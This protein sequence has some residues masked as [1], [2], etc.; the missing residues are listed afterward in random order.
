MDGMSRYGRKAC[1]DAV[2]LTGHRR[3]RQAPRMRLFPAL[4]LLTGCLGPAGEALAQARPHPA[5]AAP[6][7]GPKFGATTGLGAGLPSTKP[8]PLPP[9][10]DP[11]AGGG[12]PARRAVSS[13]TGFVVAPGR[14]LTNWHVVEGCAELRARNARGVEVPATLA[15][16]DAERDLALL[17]T[18]GQGGGET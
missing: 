17:A 13:G 15:A 16:R 7:L 18:Q 2:R 12:R 8:P 3:D 9:G 6:S 14:L 4:L 11:F 10:S 1:C 5:Q